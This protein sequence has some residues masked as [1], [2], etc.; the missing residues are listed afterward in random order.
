MNSITFTAAATERL[1]KASD[2]LASR[3]HGG[4]G[5]RATP[6]ICRSIKTVVRP[7][8]GEPYELGP[9][10]HLDS[11]DASETQDEALVVNVRTGLQVA[12]FPVSFFE[13]GPHTIDFINGEFRLC[14]PGL[15]V[16]S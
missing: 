7:I 9:R 4:E 8:R 10:L 6:L 12:L 1:Q 11:R 14:D 16:A 2:W 3:R 13:F 5:G 15:G